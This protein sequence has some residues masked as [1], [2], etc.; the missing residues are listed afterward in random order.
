MWTGGFSCNGLG[1][2]SARDSTSSGNWNSLVDGN[3]AERRTWP[4]ANS[5][6]VHKLAS[7]CARHGD[8]PGATLFGKHIWRLQPQ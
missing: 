3:D 2:I 8:I 6:A 1:Y 4:A 7:L 5:P